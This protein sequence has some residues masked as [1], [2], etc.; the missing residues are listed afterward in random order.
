MGAQLGGDA[1]RRGS[2]GGVESRTFSILTIST[3]AMGMGFAY[4]LGGSGKIAILVF[5]IRLRFRI[6][7]FSD[8]RG[9]ARF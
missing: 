5:L 7:F 1:L 4:G 6:L 9:D 8:L 2:S 3:R